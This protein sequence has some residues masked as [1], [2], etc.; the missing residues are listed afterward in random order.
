M[1]SE[2]RNFLAI[3]YD[4]LEELNLNV[5]EQR[6]KRVP[7]HKIQEERL[8]YLS[9]EKDSESYKVIWARFRACASYIPGVPW[10]EGSGLWSQPKNPCPF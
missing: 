1:P 3:P 9:G 4:E 6:M 5:K 2:L 7:L 10:R 8:E